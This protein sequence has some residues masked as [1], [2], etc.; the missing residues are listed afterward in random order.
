MIF[1]IEVSDNILT[2]FA[3]DNHIMIT[4]SKIG[5]LVGRR[6]SQNSYFRA[7][8]SDPGLIFLLSAVHVLHDFRFEQNN[9]TT[10]VKHDCAVFLLHEY[11]TMVQNSKIVC[12][13]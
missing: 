11:N 7:R 8:D 3:F 10:S 2:S 6:D 9:K 5:S 12:F 4:R 1:Q 13:A